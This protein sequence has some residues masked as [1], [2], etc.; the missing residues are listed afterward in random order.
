MDKCIIFDIDGT[1]AN[2]EHRKHFVNGAKKDWPSF[3]KMIPF[4]TPIEQTIYLNNLLDPCFTGPIFVCSGRS[5]DEKETTVK[6]LKENGVKYDRLFMRKSGDYRADYIIKKEILDEIRQGGYE[7]WIIFDDRQ[8]V[9]DMWRE[10]GLFVLQADPD[11]SHTHHHGY[12]FHS[13]IE[14]PLTIM[15]GPSGAGKTTYLQTHCNMQNVI[16]SD[17]IREQ[18]CGDFREQSRNDEVFNVMHE[19]ADTRLHAGL[20]VIL[21]A[22]HLK[23][24]DRVKAAKLVPDYI[25]VKYMVINRP[26][27]EKIKDGCWRNG[28]TVKGR[29][30]IEHHESVFQSNLKDIKSGDNLPNVKVELLI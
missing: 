6:W 11:P 21:D 24:K 2:L 14:F 3:N 23:N 12:K 25:P 5:E 18:L 4:D 13:S 28:V 15:V 22:T 1:V 19:L 20:P 26:L 7:P 16:S 29:P 30:L 9:V 8:C 27:K 10:Q 17:L